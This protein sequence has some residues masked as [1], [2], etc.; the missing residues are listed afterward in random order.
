[1][2]PSGDGECKSTIVLPQSPTRVWMG[3]KSRVGSVFHVRRKDRAIR[4]QG[5][6]F[7]GVE[8][9]LALELSELHFMVLGL[10][11]RICF[12]SLFPIA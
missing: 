2:Q 1:M 4:Q 7:L 5:P 10:S 3:Y 12:V 8:I 11:C 9:G 6:A